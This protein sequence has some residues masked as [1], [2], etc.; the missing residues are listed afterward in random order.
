MNGLIPTQILIDGLII[1]LVVSAIILGGMLINPRVM[2]SDY[3]PEIQAHVP[4]MTASDKKQQAV[5]GV[6]FIG[7][8]LIGLFYS[9]WRL[10]GRSGEVAFLPLFL[11]TYLVFAFCNLWD[12]LILDY[13]IHIILKPKALFVE[14]V[15][16]YAHYN[17]FAF[18]FK[19]FLRGLLIG[20]VLSL[21]VSLI[22]TI[23]FPLLL[24]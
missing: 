9:N 10:V 8:T 4:P 13:F 7:F 6:F 22:S 16:R 21:I 18:H 17:T 5:L 20:L 2:L 19:G 15:E 12:L 14:G 24:R 3:P 23:I 1:S 11:N